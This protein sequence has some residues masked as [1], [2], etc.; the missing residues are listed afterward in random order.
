MSRVI[1]ANTAATPEQDALRVT[2][3]VRLVTDT[4]EGTGVDALPNGVYGFTYSPA[5]VNAPLYKTRRFRTYETHK[6]KDGEVILTGFV[7]PEHA[8]AIA[9][10]TDPVD[11]IVQPEPEPE[12]ETLVLIP[13][14]RIAHHRLFA[15]HTEH[16][17]KLRVGPRD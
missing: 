14:S 17:I 4:E 5:L 7:S 6:L 1:Y 8:T 2:H 3:Q 12:T 9:T 10:A 13:Y 11:I 16:G 15:F